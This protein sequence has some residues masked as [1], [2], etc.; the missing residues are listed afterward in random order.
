[1]PKVQGRLGAQVPIGAQSQG[2]TPLV[3]G[4]KRLQIQIG[5][6]IAQGPF[7]SRISAKHPTRIDRPIGFQF[8]RVL[9]QIGGRPP[10]HQRNRVLL[11]RVEAGQVIN[12]QG[13]GTALGFPGDL[14]FKG[15][16]MLGIHRNSCGVIAEFDGFK[17][18]SVDHRLTTVG[19]NILGEIPTPKAGPSELIN[20]MI[21]GDSVGNRC[22]FTSDAG[23]D[24]PS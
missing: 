19:A 9:T 13:S 16:K 8:V 21:E 1:M 24:V 11:N 23:A 6:V 20:G 14:R 15:R 18:I 3:P 7:G 22:N 12:I 5:G 10:V 17:D 4:L 2:M